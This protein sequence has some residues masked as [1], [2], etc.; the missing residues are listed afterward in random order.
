MGPEGSLP[1][2]QEFIT[3]PHLEI[4]APWRT[5]EEFEARLCLDMCTQWWG[6]AS[7]GSRGALG[8]GEPLHFK[9]HEVWAAH[10]PTDEGP[11]FT[12]Y[13]QGCTLLVIL[14][15]THKYFSRIF[16]FGITLYSTLQYIT[17]R[18][19]VLFCLY[20]MT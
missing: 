19:L 5:G 11:I 9:L 3:G 20:Y 17:L 4:D 1:C 13:R 8:K 14:L 10:R 12:T 6:S 16:Q 7:D 2:S 18:F 15:Q